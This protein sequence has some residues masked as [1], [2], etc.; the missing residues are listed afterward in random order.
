MF[1]PILGDITM[2]PFETGA[3]SQYFVWFDH[4]AC[5]PSIYTISQY[6]I[7]IPNAE[8]TSGGLIAKAARKAQKLVIYEI[9]KN[10][11]VLAV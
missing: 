5:I 3:I 10:A 7:L 2:V 11:P 1:V 6:C 4:V 8:L 9:I